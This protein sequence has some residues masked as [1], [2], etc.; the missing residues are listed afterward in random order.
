[1]TKE[2]ALKLVE[3]DATSIIKLEKKFLQDKDIFKAAVKKS[4]N[5]ISFIEKEKITKE[6]AKSLIEIAPEM[7]GKLPEK[8]L[9]D[10]ELALLAL[11]KDPMSIKH[12]VM[13]EKTA[14]YALRYHPETIAVIN[15][16]IL[17]NNLDLVKKIIDDNPKIIDKIPNASLE[18]LSNYDICIAM[19][20]EGD[21]NLMRVV[22]S[23]K[24]QESR[25]LKEYLTE[26]AKAKVDADPNFLE[27]VPEIIL[28]ENPETVIKAV[29]KDA[30]NIKHIPDKMLLDPKINWPESISK[31]KIFQEA[32][33]KA[34]DY[35]EFIKEKK[36]E[37]EQNSK[38]EQEEKLKQ[39][40]GTIG[41]KL[42]NFMSNMFSSNSHA[43]NPKGKNND[44][45]R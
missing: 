30:N 35:F 25:A 5:V 28:I 22:T 21:I 42:K 33:K 36:Q 41:Y 8:F 23:E 7:S 19:A 38:I 24:V 13:T 29:E 15:P 2:E 10:Q 17:N 3:Q 12:F 34:K 45:A 14:R 16:I 18:S 4:S 43:S 27:N 6:M 9:E 26:K 40:A 37:A 20:V 11:K 44:I 39:E 1:M 32:I 31:N